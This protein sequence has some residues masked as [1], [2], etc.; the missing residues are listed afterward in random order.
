MKKILSLIVLLAFW[1]VPG[2]AHPFYVSI[3]QLDFNAENHTI[4]ISLKVFA[5]DLLLGLEQTGVSKIFLGEEKEN[6]NAN[7]YINKYIHSHLNFKVNDKKVDYT[8]VGKEMET[9]V[10]WNYL[11]IEN[12]LALNKIEVQCNLLTEVFDSQ[13]NIIQ[14]NNRG[15]I[16]NMLLNKRKTV[17]T[18]TY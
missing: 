12:I 18:I 16:K 15:E 5:N 9:D 10:V 3:C 2:R 4:E 8:F 7:E 6:P 1:S 17:D 13:S 14:V 11:E